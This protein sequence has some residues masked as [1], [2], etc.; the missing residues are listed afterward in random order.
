[1]FEKSREYDKKLLHLMRNHIDESDEDSNARLALVGVRMRR[2][3]SSTIELTEAPDVRSRVLNV[4]HRL[5]RAGLRLT[6]RL[7]P[8]LDRRTFRAWLFSHR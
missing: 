8:L 7:D 1:M 4:L 5:R 6:G 2:T 3:G